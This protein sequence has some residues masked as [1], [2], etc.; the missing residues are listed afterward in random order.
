MGRPPRVPDENGMLHCSA[1]DEDK[2]A[3]LF[4]QRPNGSYDSYDKECRNRKTRTYTKR[5]TQKD[6]KDVRE[7]AWVT[8][9]RGQR[10]LLEAIG[11]EWPPKIGTDEDPHADLEPP[12][13]NNRYVSRQE[14]K[15]LTTSDPELQRLKDHYAKMMDDDYMP[16]NHS[17][18]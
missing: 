7:I 6:L 9:Y 11:H 13:P 12:G 18:E 10:E 16:P 17:Q 15:N 8:W 14:T 2:A 4:Y 3:E 1:C 5:S